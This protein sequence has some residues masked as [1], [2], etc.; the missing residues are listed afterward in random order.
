MLREWASK[1]PVKWQRQSESVCQPWYLS[2]SQSPALIREGEEFNTLIDKISPLKPVANYQA[3]AVPGVFVCVCVCVCVRTLEA[4]C[5]PVHML[6]SCRSCVTCVYI[7]ICSFVRWCLFT[8]GIT[9][10]HTAQFLTMFPSVDSLIHNLERI[11]ALEE[12]IR[13]GE[14]TMKKKK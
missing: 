9:R 5:V 11:K 13:Q 4:T 2:C 10:L 14:T 1:A 6:Q 8:A 7:C 3:A 12:E